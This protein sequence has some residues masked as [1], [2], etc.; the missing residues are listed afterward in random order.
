MINNEVI[1]NKRKKL[2]SELKA[3]ASGKGI[4]QE[5][6]GEAANIRANNVNRILTGRYSPYLDTFISMAVA[7]GYDLVLVEKK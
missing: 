5:Q 7:A 3:G 2:L 1:I 6:I 4:T